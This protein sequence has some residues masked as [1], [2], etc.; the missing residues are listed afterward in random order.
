[1]HTPEKGGARP[2]ENLTVGTMFPQDRLQKFA[3]SE[4]VRSMTVK[5]LKDMET[6][7]TPGGEK[8]K[9]TRV[10]ALTTHDLVSLEG[11]FGDYRLQIVA[12]YRGIEQLSGTLQVAMAAGG[13]VPVGS[14]CCCC[15]TPCCS[16]C[17]AAE[18]DPFVN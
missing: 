12:N 4:N 13:V 6:I 14:S 1:M 16:C 7:F 5:D 17:A 11:L 8:I 10:D 15:C 9:N 2:P 18:T 3:V